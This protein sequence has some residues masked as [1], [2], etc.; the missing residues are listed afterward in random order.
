MQFHC[1]NCRY[2]CDFEEM[3]MDADL[4]A[5]IKIL[6]TFGP[7][8]NLVAAYTELFGISPLKTRRKKWRL[9]LEET[10]R[11]FDSESFAYQKKAYR[12]SPAGIVEALNVVVHRHWDD[13]LKN[14][15]YLKT[16][17]IS[18]AETADKT[19]G[20]QFEKA[21]R[22]REEGLMSG[23]RSSPSLNP[24]HQGREENAASRVP[25]PSGEEGKGEGGRL[26]GEQ[27]A[28]NQ[29]RCREII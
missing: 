18:M 26:T 16:I 19:A 1:P 25:S 8:A 27:I 7:H 29:R 15:N 4:H 13:Y 28:E 9:L 21:L 10:K 14:H 24:S 20:R 17:M 22:K 3:Q 11:L 23:D 6:P 5:I 2:E 12:I